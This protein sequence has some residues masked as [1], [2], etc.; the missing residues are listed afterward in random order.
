MAAVGLSGTEDHRRPLGFVGGVGIVL[1]LEADGGALVV[2][3]ALLAG[4]GAV[5][6]VAAVDLDAGLVGEDLEV[7]AGGG[8]VK[9]RGGSVDVAGGIQHPVVVIA[10]AVADLLVVGGDAVA[11]EVCRAEVERRAFHGSDFARGHKRVV[12]RRVVR[13]VDIKD[14]VHD[15]VRSRIAREIKVGVVGHVDDGRRI[16]RGLVGDVDAVVIGEGIGDVGLHGTGEVAIAVGRIAQQL[17]VLLVGFHHLIDLILPALGTAV[18]AVSEVVLRQLDGLSVEGEAALVDAV[19]I[20]ADAGAEVGLVVLREIIRHFVESQGHILQFPVFVVHHQRH[21]A[22]AEVGDADLGAVGVRQG[23]QRR[24]GTVIGS[25]EIGGIESR[26]GN[27][28]FLG[29]GRKH[30]DGRRA[31]ECGYRFH[32]DVIF[33]KYTHFSRNAIPAGGPV[34][35]EPE[36]H[37]P[38]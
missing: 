35:A 38:R 36:I 7:D 20:P 33:S 23:V 1:G 17:D 27:D 26:C 37:L 30:Q 31:K 14:I 28:G 3:D 4:D 11:D 32:G 2:H 5:E 24:G 9:L 22:A 18:Q 10:V 16:G 13:S 19:G 34:V 15:A 29:A 12:H 6:E 8:A 25:F 21:D